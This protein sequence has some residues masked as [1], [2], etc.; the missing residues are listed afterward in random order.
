MRTA[1][2]I[3][4][5]T[6]IVIVSAIALT[7]AGT[8][9][10]NAIASSREA[11][12]IIPYGESV[13]VDGKQMN[14]LVRGDHEQTVVLLP[15]FGTAAPGI[16]FEPLIAELEDSYRVVVIEPFGSGLSDDTDVPR[17]SDNYV[18]EVHA[19]LS[20]LGITR[21]ALAAHSI[22]GVYSL[23]YAN[24]YPEEVTA[25]IGID[26]SVPTQPG[27]DDALPVGMLRGMKTL[28]LLRQL[29]AAGPDPLKGLPYSVEQREQNRILTLRNGITNAFVSEAE[30]TG[31]NFAD[32]A[33]LRFPADLPVRLIVAEGDDGEVAGWQTLHEEQAAQVTN[34]AVVLI[35]G[36]HY[37]H[38]Q[39]APAVA[40]AIS[41]VLG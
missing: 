12:Q 33:G 4:I 29:D 30:L 3:I 27:A 5:R 11:A 28:G 40:A 2:K 37:L 8:T 19:A 18:R 26:S 14:V 13:T 15:G 38:H 35:P 10:G 34:G 16:D 9:V 31:Q 23:V 21:Y 20:E 22:S 24:A 39:Q 25:F 36:D 41:A 17:T 32:A 7:L 6:L 1:G